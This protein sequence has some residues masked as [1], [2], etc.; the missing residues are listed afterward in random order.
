MPEFVIETLADPRLDCYR[1]LR[2]KTTQRQEIFVAEGEKLVRRLL[3]S[4]CPTLSVVCTAE[5]RDLLADQIPDSTPVFLT[6]ASVI[7]QLVG[8]KFHRGLLAAGIPPAAE[9]LE[10]VLSQRLEPHRGALVVVC[11]HISDPSNLGAIIRSATAFGASAIVVGPAGT[12]PYSRRVLRTSMGAVLELPLVETADWPAVQRTL[13]DF[14]FVSLAAVLEES[15][16][17]VQQI[18]RPNRA[19]LWLGNEDCG[20]DASLTALC[21]YRVKIPMANSQISLNVSVAAGVLLHHLARPSEP[22]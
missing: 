4:H 13:Q 15:A 5:G 11:P 12:N 19:A 22:A 2:Q 17:P 10:S 1:E 3:A 9:T 8:F 20:L 16:Q 7:S 14:Q 21:Q 18:T 6:T